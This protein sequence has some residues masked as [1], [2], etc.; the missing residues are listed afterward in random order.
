VANPPS[1]CSC[2]TGITQSLPN[3]SIAPVMTSM[4]SCAL[5]SLSGGAPAGLRSLDAKTPESAPQRFAVHRDAI[6]GDAIEGRLVAL[7]V[8]I[9]AQRAADTLS[10]G[11][12]FDRQARQP[13][14][15]RFY[16]QAWSHECGSLHT[17]KNATDCSVARCIKISAGP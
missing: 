7:R 3:G 9:L 10:Q 5:C 12:R 8:D 6:H 11:Q 15:D 17:M 2:S 1:T 4:A 14:R 16:G 13:R